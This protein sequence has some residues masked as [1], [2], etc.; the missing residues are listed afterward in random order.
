[1]Y[2]CVTDD[3]HSNRTPYTVAIRKTRAGLATLAVASCLSAAGL[4]PAAAQQLEATVREIQ[5]AREW[6]HVPVNKSVLIETNLPA[7]R[8]QTL[9]PDIANIQSIS[10]TQVL[11]TG[12]SF[13]RTQVIIWSGEQRQVFDVSVE[14][15]LD[16]LKE[17]IRR[18]D[19]LGQVEAFPIMDT[20]VLNGTVSDADAAERIM[21]VASIFASNVQ[22]H[23]Q[24][25]GEQQVLL[26]VTIAEM[27]RSVLRQLGINGFLAGE[28][29]RDVIVAN[30]VGQVNPSSFGYGAGQVT[31]DLPFVTPGTAIG[32]NTT[33]SLGFPGIQLQMFFQAMRENGLLKILAEPNLVTISGR[34]ASF[35]AGGEFPIPVPQTTS[36]GTGNTIT[37]EFREFGARLAFTPLVLANQMIRLNLAPEVSELDFARGVSIGGFVVP[38]LNVRRTETTVELGSG[39]SLAISGLLSENIRAVSTRVPALGDLP[40]LGALFAS[41]EFRKNLSELVVVCTPELVSGVNPD[42]IPPLPGHDYTEP[43]DWQLF[44]LG[45]LE[46]PPKPASMPSD[47]MPTAQAHRQPDVVEVEH[48]QPDASGLMGN[49]G[50][51]DNET[52]N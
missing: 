32:G 37:I 24:V 9:S 44:A 23:L 25:A 46:A 1:M 29:F 13:G 35:L 5:V 34:T 6:I 52:K 8:Q 28:D 49:W 27:S 18:V 16:L 21:E 51:S 17:A 50:M 40:I 30:N 45:L 26:R 2:G 10:P 39:Q 3:A 38:G 20:V 48:Q 42:Q 12:V 14:L 47:E 15:E 43:D 33:L 22:N 41:T 7:T 19:P 4:Q 36:A 11:V 31:N